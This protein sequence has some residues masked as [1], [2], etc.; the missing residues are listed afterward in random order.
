MAIKLSWRRP[1]PRPWRLFSRR[2]LGCPRSRDSRP[3]RLNPIEPGRLSR[4]TIGRWSSSR[5]ETGL[6]SE[7]RWTDCEE[8]LSP[9]NLISAVRIGDPRRSCFQPVPG[10]EVDGDYPSYR[11]GYPFDLSE[12]RDVR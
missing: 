12:D 3:Q 8:H 11:L 6:A 4:T 7:Q 1:S 5:L 9:T 2:V 10:P